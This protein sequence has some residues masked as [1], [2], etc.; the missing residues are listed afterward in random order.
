MKH[1]HFIE[2]SNICPTITLNV[3]QILPALFWETI[4]CFTDI[5]LL[6][7]N[8]YYEGSYALGSQ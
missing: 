2:V 1:K 7:T 8:N 6:I 3:N 4:V 5:I